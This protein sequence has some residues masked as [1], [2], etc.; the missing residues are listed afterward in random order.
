MTPAKKKTKNEAIGQS[1]NYYVVENEPYINE[2]ARKAA[3]SSM[4]SSGKVKIYT[5]AEIK[6]YLSKQQLKE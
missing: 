6:E 1:S 5:K 3:F 4:Y 2:E